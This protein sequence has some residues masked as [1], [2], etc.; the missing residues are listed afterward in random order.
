MA[1]RKINYE[2]SR[3]EIHRTLEISRVFMAADKNHDKNISLK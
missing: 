2:E 1:E 3:N